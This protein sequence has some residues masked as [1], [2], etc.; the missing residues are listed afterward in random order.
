MADTFL[1]RQIRI[2]TR[3]GE[4]AAD[5]AEKMG[6]PTDGGTFDPTLIDLSAGQR[7]YDQYTQT[8]AIA[9]ALDGTKTPAIGG[10]AIV[11][12]LGGGFPITFPSNF[13]GLGSLLS[14][15]VLQDGAQYPFIFRHGA[16]WEM[17]SPGVFE[18]RVIIQA[19]GID[20]LAAAL[21]YE[22]TNF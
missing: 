8:G 15:V 18:D 10:A 3:F 16:D 4:I 11:N 5:L 19:D 12:I 14:G 17:V 13:V 6:F 2:D 7:E 1:E 20:Q 22:P 9:F 21:A